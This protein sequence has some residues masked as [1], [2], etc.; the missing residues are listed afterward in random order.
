MIKKFDVKNYNL[1]EYLE[2][3]NYNL[4]EKEELIKL[5]H[6]IKNNSERHLSL[7]DLR[8][9]VLWKLNRIIYI[10]ESLL[11]DL[12]SLAKS[13]GKNIENQ[14]IKRIIRELLNSTGVQLPMASTILK[15]LRSD[16]FPIIDI[17]AY[18]AL[19]GEK[20]NLG[21]NCKNKFEI[22]V[23]YI[24]RLKEIS[25]ETGINFDKIDEGLYQFDKKENKDIEN[26]NP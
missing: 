2:G 7:E 8:R 13:K 22:Y 12:N 1:K 3:Y 5:S 9:V 26:Q 14:E 20:K 11:S 16:I 6:E 21:E 25:K 19:F 23:G 18:R 15:F 4:N 17:R 24:K 10:D